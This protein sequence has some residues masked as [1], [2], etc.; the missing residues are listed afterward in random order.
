LNDE[1]QF[2]GGEIAIARWRARLHLCFKL[3]QKLAYLFKTLV[4]LAQHFTPKNRQA[5]AEFDAQPS[6]TARVK[7]SRPLKP[8]VWRAAAQRRNDPHSYA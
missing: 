8:A 6:T 7:L 1:R 5:A 2:Q 3:A 4:H